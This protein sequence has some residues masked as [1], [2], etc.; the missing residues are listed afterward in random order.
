[1]EKEIRAEDLFAVDKVL[2][3]AEYTATVKLSSCGRLGLPPVLHLKDYSFEDTTLLAK[4]NQENESKIILAVLKNVIAENIDI[5][6]ITSQDALEIL[7]TIQGTFY[8]AYIDGLRYYVDETLS[9]DKLINKENISTATIPIANIKTIPLADGL[10]TPINL[11]TKGC[12][13]KF[14]YPRLVY[15]SLATEY[16]SNKFAEEDNKMSQIEQKIKDH[17][18]SVDEIKEFGEYR[19]RRFYELME[20]MNALSLLEYNGK[21]LNNIDEKLHYI[22]KVPAALMTILNSIITEKFKFGVDPEVTFIDNITDKPITRRF[23]F[24][25]SHFLQTLEYR[26]AD[27]VRI[28]FG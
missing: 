22:K 25:F 2:E 17:V 26:N 27:D 3:N 7:L 15:D 19:D 12:R 18:A 4:A 24:R 10:K 5:S 6:K 16:I 8:S 9:G 28:S 14:D 13:V 11:E 20:V 23:N 21:E 1:M